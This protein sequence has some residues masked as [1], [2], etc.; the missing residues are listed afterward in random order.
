VDVASQQDGLE[1][2]KKRSERG[3]R[4]VF[5]SSFNNLLKNHI[6]AWSDL[7]DVAGVSIWGDPETEKNF[8]FNIYHMLIAAPKDEGVSSIGAK[9]LTG[10][11]YRGH[12]FWDTEIFLMPF[13]IY[14]LP[15]AA[16]N[17]LLYR[18]KRLDKAR[19]IAKAKG[20]KGAMFPWESAG[21]GEE[22]TPAWA[23]D[24]DGKV[25]RIHT[26]NMEHHITADIAYALYHYYNVTQDK[27]FLKYYGYEMMFETAR[28][29]ASRVEYNKKR[30]KYEIKHVIGPDEFHN[31]V[32]NNAFTNMMAKWN[33]IT[34]YKLFQK[35]KKKEPS[36]YKKL[37]GKISISNKEVK[38]WRDISLSITINMRK[39]RI[40]EQ[41][42]GYFR[43]RQIKISNWDENYI[44]VISK[45]LTPREYGK[46]Q[47][48][49]QADVIMLLYLLAD[50]FRTKAKKKN[51]EYYIQRTLHKS[52]LSLP[53][54]AL[55]AVAVGDKNRAHRFFN[56]ALHTDIS[57]IHKNTREGIH[58]ACIGGTWQVMIRGFAGV[59][60]ERGVL[61]IT[62]SLPNT[63]RKILFSLYWRGTL[64]KLEVK[65]NK[66]KIQ[67]V[68][69]EKK[70]GKVKIKIFGVQRELALNKIYE[71]ERRKSRPES[72]G[73]YL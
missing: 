18:Y 23:K 70:R 42:D 2:L 43:K 13:Y 6:S 69:K 5:R 28:F 26:G 72:L 57:N 53:M 60:V 24:L 12:V 32:N 21:L 52:S 41:F 25:I 56:N 45:K 33:M 1:N 8:R 4:K 62:P 50:I 48:I 16:R 71:F 9:A 3:F 22:E 47:L 65:T 63:W 11:G 39:D 55:I 10:E 49:K 67:P 17:M 40:I 44:P 73:Y 30:K 31:D 46:T 54:Y 35:L 51:Y 37:T 68:S 19:E 20:F 7:W 59:R 15:D 14:V 61:S 66:V 38:A 36:V 58:A 29:W 34:A 64:L 27:E